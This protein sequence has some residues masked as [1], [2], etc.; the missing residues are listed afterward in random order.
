MGVGPHR[1]EGGQ[2]PP[3]SGL[4]GFFMEHR[5]LRWSQWPCFRC[6]C[7]SRKMPPRCGSFTSGSNPRNKDTRFS[8]SR[9][10][11]FLNAARTFLKDK[12]EQVLILILILILNLNLKK[13][14]AVFKMSPASRWR[15]N[16]FTVGS[17]PQPGSPAGLIFYGY[18][19]GT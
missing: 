4:P 5:Q 10:A 1:P 6:R 7:Y 16:I 14:S 2:S 12:T 17:N 8:T 11:P 18:R 3:P 9:S 13:A 19:C 15:D